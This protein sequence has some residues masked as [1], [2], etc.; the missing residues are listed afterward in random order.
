MNFADYYK[1]S[2]IDKNATPKDIKNVLITLICLYA[3]AP[4]YSQTLSPT[5]SDVDYVGNNVARQN[6]DIYIPPGLT[7]PAPVIVFIHGGGWYSG[8]KGAGNIPYFQL[9][10]NSGFICADI[11]YRLSTDSVWPAQIEDCKTAIR[12]L[13]ANATTYNIDICRFGVIGESAGGHLCAMVGTSAGVAKL[14]G[15]HQGHTNVTSRVQA[16]VDMY[17]P[18]DFLKEDGY[19]PASCTTGGLFHEYNSFETYLLGIDYLHNHT[20]IVRTANPITYITPD[21]ARFFIIHGGADCVVPTYQSKLLDSMLTVAGTPADT[22]IISEEQT[23]GSPYFTD[24]LRTPLYNKFFLKHLSIPCSITG[25]SETIFQNISVFPNPATTEIKINF[26]SSNNFTTEIINTYGETVLK[27]QNQNTINIS[28][29][30]C[31]VYFLKLISANK[32]YTQKF[33]KL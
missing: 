2:G 9:S 7:S 31:G 3:T 13:K 30:P 33:I 29:L 12:F 23:H 16:V 4:S 19:Y 20:A 24:Y 1:I 14:E 26:P 22:F 15:S 25:I 8:S 32:F 28:E 6:M 5:Y 10:Y 21:D 27:T 17:G 18:T 11:N